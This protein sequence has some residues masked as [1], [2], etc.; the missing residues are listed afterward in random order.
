[1]SMHPAAYSWVWCN[2]KLYAHCRSGLPHN[3]VHFPST[4]NIVCQGRGGTWLFV[5][6]STKIAGSGDLGV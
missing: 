2:I 4:N 5:V 3:A 1:M 6:V